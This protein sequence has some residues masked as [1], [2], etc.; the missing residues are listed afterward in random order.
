M[1]SII[2]M[3]VQMWQST[4]DGS[5]DGIR[6]RV[7]VNFWFGAVRTRLYNIQKVK[8]VNTPKPV[9]APKKVTVKSVK[10]GKKKAVVKL[11]KVSGAKGYQIQ[12]STKKNF[13]TAYTRSKN[14]K[15]TSVTIKKLTSKKTYYFR[16]KAYKTNA[17]N[18]KVYSKKWSKVKKVKIK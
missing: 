7:D 3:R 6:G 8:T 4:S 9:T 2:T 14:T 13:K 10:A 17:A 12:Y 18:K 1:P 15:K 11:K 5:V 16:V